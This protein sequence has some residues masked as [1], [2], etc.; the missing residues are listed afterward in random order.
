MLF[1]P[2]N[3]RRCEFIA[4]ATSS[5]PD[6]PEYARAFLYTTDSQIILEPSFANIT[7]QSDSG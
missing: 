7:L 4:A 3:Q 2:N 5:I 1:S 6:G